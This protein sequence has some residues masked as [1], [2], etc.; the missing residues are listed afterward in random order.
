[1]K[2]SYYPDTDTLYIDLERISKPPLKVPGADEHMAQTGKHLPHTVHLSLVAPHLRKASKCTLSRQAGSRCL[3][4]AKDFVVD[5]EGAPVGLEI[6]YASLKVDLS[7]L[8][9][10]GLAFDSLGY[11][12]QVSQVK[13][14][15]SIDPGEKQGTRT[16]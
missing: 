4:V 16:V 3:Q 8:D 11:Q 13:N 6:E 10:Q 5:T 2:L 7:R 9:L 12:K 14:A 1:M 15:R